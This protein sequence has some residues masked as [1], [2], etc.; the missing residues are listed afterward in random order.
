MLSL[1]VVLLGRGPDAVSEALWVLTAALIGLGAATWR[2]RNTAPAIDAAALVVTLVAGAAL[3]GS[4]HSS[5][6]GMA[7]FMLCAI[8]PAVLVGLCRFG[9]FAELPDRM[10]AIGLA[11]TLALFLTCA[12]LIA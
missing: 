1:A 11:L 7:A 8:A 10:R 4:V 2:T 3:I 5:A 12:A 9:P 6:I